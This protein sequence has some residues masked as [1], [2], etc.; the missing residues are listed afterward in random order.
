MFKAKQE[1]RDVTLLMEVTP[2]MEF[3]KF[4]SGMF[5]HCSNSKEAF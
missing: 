3:Q 4:R 2:L 1:M 5:W